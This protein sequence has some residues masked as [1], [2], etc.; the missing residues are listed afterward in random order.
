MGDVVNLRRARKRRDREAR[1]EVAER[2]RVA[3]G[4]T[5]PERRATAA[6]RRRAAAELDGARLGE[7]RPE[8]R[9]EPQPERDD[10]PRA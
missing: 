4:R 5:L 1:A 3:H 8:P 9:P 6:E 10:A 2:N 7:S